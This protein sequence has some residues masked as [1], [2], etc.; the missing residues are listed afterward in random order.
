MSPNK[1]YSLTKG[2][3]EC[4]MKDDEFDQKTSNNYNST[5]DNSNIFETNQSD[6]SEDIWKLIKKY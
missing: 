2:R 5:H 3:D 1:N 6:N 4:K